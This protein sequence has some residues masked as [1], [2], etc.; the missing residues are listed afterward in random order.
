MAKKDNPTGDA[1]TGGAELTNL[2]V[3]DGNGS[4]NSRPP[5]THLVVP[6]GTGGGNACMLSIV[7]SGRSFSL[8]LTDK[9]AALLPKRVTLEWVQTDGDKVLLK[10]SPPQVAE[11]GYPVQTNRRMRPH[12]IFPRCD[13]KLSHYPICVGDPLENGVGVEFAIEKGVVTLPE[14]VA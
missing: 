11:R 4:G 13:V 7:E 12:I 14:T 3:I 6:S 5:L 8:K 1:I 9:L 2:H 10:L